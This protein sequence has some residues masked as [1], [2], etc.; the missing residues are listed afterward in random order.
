MPRG[1]EVRA[2]LPWSESEEGQGITL[3]VKNLGTIFGAMVLNWLLFCK[4]FPLCAVPEG[5]FDSSAMKIHRL[6]WCNYPG[7]DT[8]YLIWARDLAQQISGYDI[9]VKD[10]IHFP[11]PMLGG[12]LNSSCRGSS[13][14]FWPAQAPAVYTPTPTLHI[15]KKNLIFLFRTESM[16]CSHFL[17]NCLCPLR[18]GLKVTCPAFSR[19]V[20]LL[21]CCNIILLLEWQSLKRTS[22]SWDSVL[23]VPVLCKFFIQSLSYPILT[24]LHKSEQSHFSSLEHSTVIFVSYIWLALPDAKLYEGET[25]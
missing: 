6:L 9:F 21:H 24:H 17:S 14:L 11:A 18:Q 13:V 8:S 4:L 2:R 1:L 19:T 22:E 20:I 15:I 3:D 23:L 12:C 16:A 10:P 7:T 25:Y 5:M